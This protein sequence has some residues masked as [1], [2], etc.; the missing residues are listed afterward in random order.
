MGRAKKS[1]PVRDTDEFRTAQES[2]QFRSW[3]LTQEAAIEL[4]FAITD[5]PALKGHLYTREGL[6]IAEQEALSRYASAQEAF[7]D[8]TG[9]VMRFVYF[10]GETLRREVEGTWAALPAEPP[11][12]GQVPVIDAPY[13]LTFYSPVQMMRFALNRRTSHEIVTVY[14]NAVRAHQKWVED[15]RPPRSR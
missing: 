1:V 10:V 13:S 8:D 3:L 6:V 7:S 15:R 11:R 5:I 9:R 2:E 14:D 12:T 4:E